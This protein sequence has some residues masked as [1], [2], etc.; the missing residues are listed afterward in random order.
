MSPYP[1]IMETNGVLFF[2]ISA[3]RSITAKFR[4]SDPSLTPS[5]ASINDGPS[6]NPSPSYHSQLFR[7]PLGFECLPRLL[8]S[9]FSPY[10]LYAMVKFVLQ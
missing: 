5:F 4:P 2:S 10:T 7:A 3:D 1:Y 9:V 8:D 6:V